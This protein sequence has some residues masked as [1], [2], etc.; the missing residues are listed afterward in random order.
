MRCNPFVRSALFAAAAALAWWPWVL[1]AG[2]MLGWSTARACYLVGITVLYVGGLSAGTQRGLT[3]AAV[4]GLVAVGVALVVHT[5]AELAF[6]LAAV[7]GVARS[8]VLYRAAPAR[9]VATEV[10]LLIGGLT[11][12]RFLSGPAVPSLGLAIWGFFLIQS[13]FFIVG[14][15][16]SRSPAPRHTDPFDEAHQRAV[17]LLERMGI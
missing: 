1:L 14:G 9:A 13:L 5:L 16:R 8:L 2:P 7:L 4:A 12:A 11:F 10:F 6:G 17:A 15:I 3:V